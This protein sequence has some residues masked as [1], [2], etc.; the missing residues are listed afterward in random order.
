MANE[1]VITRLRG[2]TIGGNGIVTRLYGRSSG[3]GTTGRM[4]R[5]RG[6]VTGPFGIDTTPTQTVN[7]FDVVR[8]LGVIQGTGTVDTWTW[9]QTS[10]PTVTLIPEPG[11]PAAVT[12]QWRPTAPTGLAST[13]FGFT[14]TATSGATT[15]TKTAT[16]TVLPHSGYWKYV[17][18]T[19]TAIQM[20]PPT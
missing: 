6:R 3:T 15:L 5:L 17:G 19:M 13:V 9:S 2:M 16:V 12:W 7:P 20:H 1:G 10:G 8:L 4:T 14:L 11:N 18:S